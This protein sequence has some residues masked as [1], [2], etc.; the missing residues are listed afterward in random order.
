[1]D[2]DVK[3]PFRM[4]LNIKIART[5]ALARHRNAIIARDQTQAHA[6]ILG[7]RAATHARARNSGVLRSSTP[8]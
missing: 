1:M 8:S 4:L 6:R 5:N 7:N 3:L 2:S